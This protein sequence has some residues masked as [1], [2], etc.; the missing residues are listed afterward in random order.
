MGRARA[1]PTRVCA[2]LSA[3]YLLQTPATAPLV[4]VLAVLHLWYRDLAR[5]GG[6]REVPFLVSLLWTLWI[7]Y[8]PLWHA[9]VEATASTPATPATMF[10]ALAALSHAADLG[11]VAEDAAQGIRTPAVLMGDAEARR[12]V[13]ALA[14][15]AIVLHAQTPIAFPPLDM[16]LLGVVAATLYE[17]PMIGIASAIGV[18]LAYASVYE[19]EVLS[20]LLRSTESS[21]GIAITSTLDLVDWAA[22]LPDPWRQRVLEGVIQAFQ[23][24]DRVGS[25]LLHLYEQA[26][27]RG[28]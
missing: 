19:L 13:V 22:T 6:A 28:M 16:L 15:G 2:A 10:L 26:L 27:R 5:M 9:G 23:G 21:H 3:A 12:Y 25:V 24:G 14:L 8:L 20:A 18:A 1:F 11:D 7:Y 17:T 4:P